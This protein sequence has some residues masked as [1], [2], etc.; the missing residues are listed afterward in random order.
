MGSDNG[1]VPYR[2]QLIIWTNARSLSIE[3]LGAIFSEILFKIKKCI[4]QNAS[5]NIV[6]EMAAILSRGDE[7]IY[8]L[9]G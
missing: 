1:L 6:C 7:L 9:L 3:P 2:R 5:E 8:D 4:H